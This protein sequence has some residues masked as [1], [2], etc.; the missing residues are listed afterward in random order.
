M[1]QAYRLHFPKR[2]PTVIM[3]GMA[4]IVVSVMPFAGHVAPTTGVVASLLARGH[5]VTVYTG[6]RYAA[7]FERLGAT[8]VPW[9]LAPDFDEHNLRATFPAVGRGGPRGVL[10]NLEHVFVRTAEGQARDLLELWDTAGWDLIVSDVMSLGAGL[11]A[12]KLDQPWATLSVLPLSMPSAAVPPAGLGLQPGTGGF[13]T[14]RDGALRGVSRLLSRPLERAHRSVRR[15]LGLP[16][17]ARRVDRAWYSPWLVLASGC[18]L[19]EFPRDDLP[20]EVH[21]V[22]RLPAAA[23]SGVPLP[24]WWQRLARAHDPTVLVTQGTFNTDPTQL[25]K[26]ALE[27]LAGEPV[28]VVATTGSAT[29][30]TL[31]FTV[32]ANALVAGLVPFSE[33]LPLTDVMVTNGGWGGV[34]DALSRGI[35]LIIAGGDLDKPDIAARVDYAR[36]GVDLNTG[37]PTARAVADAY[38]RV[39]SQPSFAERARKVAAE[40]DRCGGTERAVDLL[41]ELTR[42]REP[43]LRQV[44]NPWRPDASK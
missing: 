32:P 5:T 20:P 29:D 37:R 7:R 23:G 38:R 42:R 34:L 25:L 2:A 40:L 43:V 14:I 18:R 13:G 11:A 9:T 15:A 24:E 10:A 35:P 3:E 28:T 12:E 33:V 6:S 21:F 17:P 27:A 26:P 16:A 39:S 22:G 19:L 8:V 36:A 30:D 1:G 44:A 41:E 4:R 31:P